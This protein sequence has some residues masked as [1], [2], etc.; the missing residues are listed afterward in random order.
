MDQKGRNHAQRSKQVGVPRRGERDFSP[1]AV[2]DRMA[3]F[4]D[5]FTTH[6]DYELWLGNLLPAI[7]IHGRARE[8]SLLDVGC[9]T[10][11]SPLPM[12]ERVFR[13][14]GFRAPEARLFACLSHA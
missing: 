13:R 7:E 12:I 10:G 5:A 11:R 2:Y 3:G 1:L 6:L 8:R 9:G 14:A 4:Y